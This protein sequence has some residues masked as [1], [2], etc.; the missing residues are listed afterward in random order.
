[1][2]TTPREFDLSF[3]A[4]QP[5]TATTRDVGLL[6]LRLALGVIMVAHGTQKLFG[7]FG[8][9]GLDGAAKGF[10]AMGYPASKSMATVAGLTETL[11][12][13]GLIF[14]FITPLAAAAVMGTM[15][16]AIGVRWGAFFAPAGMEYELLLAA[17][18]AAL[19]LTGPGRLSVDNW[20]PRLRDESRAGHRWVA[21][22]LGALL[23]AVALIVRN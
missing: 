17:A 3:A 21:L 9:P 20:L 10:R 18:A 6:L 8:G 14:G 11:G 15:I 1:M 12:G 5:R 19:C 2:A 7:Y 13:V 4:A 22:A 23:A 16:N